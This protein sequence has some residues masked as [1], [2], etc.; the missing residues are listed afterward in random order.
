[1]AGQPST[2]PPPTDRSTA[3]RRSVLHAAGGTFGFLGGNALRSDD[4]A[5]TVRVE[6]GNGL[7]SVGEGTY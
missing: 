6:V 7:V 1:M 3:T 4:P 5:D 2:G